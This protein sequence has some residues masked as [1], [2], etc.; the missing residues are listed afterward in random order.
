[1]SPTR[2]ILEL[3]IT[4]RHTRE[5]AAIGEP[6]PC[7]RCIAYRPEAK[8]GCHFIETKAD[9]PKVDPKR[10]PKPEQETIW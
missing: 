6:V 8:S 4:P 2:P 7:P 9:I 10:R 5:L 1:M 3:C